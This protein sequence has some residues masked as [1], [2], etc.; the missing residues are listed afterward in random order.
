MILRM[1]RHKLLILAAAFWVALPAAA[2]NDFVCLRALIPATDLSILHSRRSRYSFPEIN[3]SQSALAIGEWEN[4]RLLSMF[5]YTEES[6]K[7]YDSAVI[8]SANRP[9]ALRTLE[10]SWFKTHTLAVKLDS[11]EV[12][13]IHLEQPSAPEH[14]SLI[15]RSTASETTYLLGGWLQENHNAKD[16]LGPIRQEIKMRSNLVRERNLNTE[17]FKAWSKAQELCKQ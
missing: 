9:Q 17:R 2:G 15:M 12:F 4:G 3:E 6:S 10:L 8:N 13:Q 14:H 7:R 1:N 16:V 11:L 5:V